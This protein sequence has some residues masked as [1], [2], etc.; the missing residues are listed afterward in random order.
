MNYD[1]TPA[2]GWGTADDVARTIRF[3]CSADSRWIN[4][5]VI[6]VDG[7]WSST[8]YL[9]EKA[10]LAKREEAPLTFTHSGKPPIA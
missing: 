8:K 5:Q 10:L 1:M 7:G 2:H 6:A 9:S 3:L 4:G